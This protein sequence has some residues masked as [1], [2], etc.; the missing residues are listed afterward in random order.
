MP[1]RSRSTADRLNAVESSARGNSSEERATS[2]QDPAASVRDLL[3][4]RLRLRGSSRGHIRDGE[5]VNVGRGLRL[6]SFFSV[7]PAVLPAFEPNA[8]S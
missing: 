1:N 8:E 7:F 5:K 4:H 2:R 6:T 3:I